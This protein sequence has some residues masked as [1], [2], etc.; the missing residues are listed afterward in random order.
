MY[1]TEDTLGVRITNVTSATR[2][3]HLVDVLG[4]HLYRTLQN[5]KGRPTT[6]RGREHRQQEW[7][8]RGK[9]IRALMLHIHTYILLRN[10]CAPRSWDKLHQS[11]FC[12]QQPKGEA[13]FDHSYI[14]LWTE[15]LGTFGLYS[16][17][18]SVLTLPT[19]VVYSGKNY[20][21]PT[22]TQ[23]LCTKKLNTSQV[24]GTN[25]TG[26]SKTAQRLSSVC[27]YDP[28]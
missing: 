5:K 10:N 19:V 11:G 18:P 25:E 12:W 15:K 7:K 28:L 8:G 14:Q 3:C 2:S 27:A 23:Y 13:N 21:N 9:V 26:D 16:Y 24:H 1:P 17:I 22:K 6:K 20:V 4:L